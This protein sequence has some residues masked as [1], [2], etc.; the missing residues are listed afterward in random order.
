MHL[1]LSSLGEAQSK[2]PEEE[3][4]MPFQGQAKGLSVKIMSELNFM[5]QRIFANLLKQLQFPQ[6]ASC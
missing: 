4:L 1:Q 3:S 5:N 6:S 2:T